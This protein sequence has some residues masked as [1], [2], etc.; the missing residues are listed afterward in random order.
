MIR[1]GDRFRATR[2]VADATIGIRRY[3]PAH[4]MSV[5]C[6]IPSG[7]VLVALDQQPEAEGFI[8][9]P[10]A[11]DQLERVLVPDDV[12]SLPEYTGYFLHLRVEHIGKWLEPL[13]PL[14]PRPGN[15]LPR[16]ASTRDA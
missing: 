12:R 2:D 5:Q 6:T 14:R 9:Y 1:N 8:G 10:E 4:S 11:Y 15:V 3:A 16:S 7:T 13:R